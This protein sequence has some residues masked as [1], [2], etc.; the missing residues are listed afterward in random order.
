MR[1][2]K[3]QELA[4]KQR[5]SGSPGIDD[6]EGDEEADDGPMAHLKKKL[7]EF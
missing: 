7:P 3:K 1:H 6:N 2:Q 5:H 4:E